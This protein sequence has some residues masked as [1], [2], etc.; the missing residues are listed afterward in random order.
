M[1]VVVDGSALTIDEVVAV[2]HRETDVVVGEDVAT[3]MRPALEVVDSAVR[4]GRVVYGVTTGF[5]ALANTR[6][7]TPEAE[8]LQVSLLRSHAAGVG[9]PLPD[10]LVRAMLLLRARTLAQG[11]S[12][13]RPVLVERLVELLRRDLLPVVP[14]Q[15]SVGAS[16]DLAPFAHLALP[17]IGEGRLRRNGEMAPAAEVLRTEGIEPMRLRPKEG[18]SLLNGTEGMLAFTVLGLHRAMRFAAAAD[19]ACALSV[20]A[21]LGS[22]R[23]FRQEV[24]RLRPH[25]G[26]QSSAA[27]I[28]RYLE[29][30]E[31]VASHHDDFTH[32]VQD[33]YSLR[34]APQVHGA[35][36]DTIDHVRLVAER[37]LGSVVDNPIVLPESGEV[38]S[39]GN[40]HGQPL[41]FA[42]DFLAIAMT[43]LGSI[44]ERR[45]DRMLD[46]Q[47][48]SGLPAFL[49]P[50]PGVN[51]GYMLAQYTA[52]ALVAENRVLSHPA[53]IESIP[54]SGSQEDHVS[55]GWGA[56]RKLWEVLAN[57][58]RVLAVELL[59]AAQGTEARAPL[60]PASA[61]SCDPRSYPPSSPPAHRGPGVD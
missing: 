13:V 35:V 15:G 40:F 17:L 53:S 46:P 36:L 42:L 26:Q 14:G 32:A 27:A 6:V 47:H 28:A 23:P 25:P 48:S 44:S 60:R 58:S 8:A 1:T 29:G 30:S 20:E 50:R 7:E 24:H 10:H 33:A 12:G 34:C 22:A 51:S 9:E 18:L 54:T 52:A 57:T 5:G 55:M 2:A 3:R 38:V 59:C 43:E 39:A 16:G 49:S 56:G 41:A 61:T 37:E 45:T 31:I 11:H 19:R 21:L 4:E